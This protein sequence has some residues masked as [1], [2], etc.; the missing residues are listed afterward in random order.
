MTRKLMALIL[1][2]GAVIFSQCSKETDEDAI[3]DLIALDTIWFNSNTEVDS[4]SNSLLLQDTS[5]I[6][7]RGV[8]T[9]TEPVI[10]I[11]VLEDSAWVSWSRGNLG[12]LYSLAR[13]DTNPCQVRC[14]RME[15]PC[16]AFAPLSCPQV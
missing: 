6:W 5:I 1:I 10:E 7:W 8:Q 2:I 3:M 14:I 4:T 13:I 11:Q 15:P 9:H 12:H 16:G